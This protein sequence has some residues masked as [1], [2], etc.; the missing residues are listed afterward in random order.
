MSSTDTAM[1][2]KQDELLLDRLSDFEATNR[3][4]RFMLHQRYQVV[5]DGLR[6]EEQLDR[7]LRETEDRCQV[8]CSYV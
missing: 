1:L 8:S 5:S 6:H 3:E 7:I 4:L 2:S